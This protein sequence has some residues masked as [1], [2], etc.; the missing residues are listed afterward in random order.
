MD[1]SLS[2]AAQD[3]S[4]RMW[5]FMQEE[6]FP[7]EPEWAAYLPEHSE[8]AHPPVMERLKESARAP[9]ARGACSCAGS[10]A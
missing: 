6:V 9:G 10:P 5:A 7:A 1:F 4:D 8:H 3:V 2:P